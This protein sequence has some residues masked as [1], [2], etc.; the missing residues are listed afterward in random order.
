LVKQCFSNLIPRTSRE[1]VWKFPNHCRHGFSGD[2][3][4]GRGEKEPDCAAGRILRQAHT[5]ISVLLV[6]CWWGEKGW[7]NR[8]RS[9]IKYARFGKTRRRTTIIDTKLDEFLDSQ[10]FL[11]MHPFHRAH[12]RPMVC[13]RSFQH[14]Y[15]CRKFNL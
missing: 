3:S 6:S 4:E 12:P 11:A 8:S 2:R 10:K 14:C 1:M 7:D 9:C 13:S 5:C 15:E